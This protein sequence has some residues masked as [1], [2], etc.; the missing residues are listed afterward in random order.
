M[1]R[2]KSRVNDIHKK[3]NW[4]TQNVITIQCYDN[5]NK[6]QTTLYRKPTD[7]QAFLRGKSGHSKT[8]K[9]TVPY[10]Q[11]LRLKTIFSTTTEFDKNLSV[12][13]HM[14]LDQQYKEEVP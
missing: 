8:L 4:K 9:S 14:F 5:N 11:P 10:C 12:I 7:Q 1:E 2:H 13:T 6:I 3:T